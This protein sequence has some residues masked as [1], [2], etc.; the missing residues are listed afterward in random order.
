MNPLMTSGLFGSAFTGSSLAN[1]IFGST[2]PFG[3]AIPASYQM[4]FLNEQAANPALLQSG[5]YGSSLGQSL[6]VANKLQLVGS[7]TNGQFGYGGNYGGL[8]GGGLGG[9]SLMYQL[10][11]DDSSDDESDDLLKYM[12]G[13]NGVGLGGIGGDQL[14][15]QLLLGSDDDDSDD[16]LEYLLTGGSGLGGL[17]GLGLGGLGRG[18]LGRGRGLGGLY[19]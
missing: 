16:L 8:V 3:S 7:A 18:G 17:G 15:Y 2:L 12:L 11:L 1:N 19:L 9:N 5:V 14:M 10:L 4:Q 6:E 13:G